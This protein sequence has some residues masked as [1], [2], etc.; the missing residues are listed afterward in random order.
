[1]KEASRILREM[2]DLVEENKLTELTFSA[3]DISLSVKKGS[4]AQFMQAPGFISPSVQ[5]AVQSSVTEPEK[6]KKVNENLIPVKSPIAG[7]F[8]RALR[9]GAEPFVYIGDH[10]EEGTVLCIVEAMKLFNELTSDQKGKIV[11]IEVENA[12]VVSEGQVLF[13]LEKA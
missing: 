1:M 11:S 6:E 4:T 3:G 13:Y 10:V 8:Y 9:P 12:N 7:V 5:P 2:V